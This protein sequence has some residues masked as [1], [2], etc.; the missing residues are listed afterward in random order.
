MPRAGMVVS[1]PE[2][3]QWQHVCDELGS[4]GL[5]DPVRSPHP[6]RPSVHWEVTVGQWA[7]SPPYL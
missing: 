4:A 6:H 7:G 1:V 3:D 2:A 5:N